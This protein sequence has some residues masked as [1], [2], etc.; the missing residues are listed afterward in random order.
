MSSDIQ[1]QIGEAIPIR[2]QEPN[3]SGYSITIVDGKAIQAN[4]LF[5][6][7]IQGMD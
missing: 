1:E 5:G 6:R 4:Q 2:L 3:E 7:I